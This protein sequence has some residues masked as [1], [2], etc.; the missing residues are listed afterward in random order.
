MALSI[1]DH[2]V[3]CYACMDVCPS[4]AIARGDQHFEIDASRCNE[5]MGHYAE[6]QCASI[7]PV[8]QALLDNNGRVLHPPGSLSGV[9]AELRLVSA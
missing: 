9:G 2:C 7:C 4:G 3:N 5:C 6:S 8:E 1:T